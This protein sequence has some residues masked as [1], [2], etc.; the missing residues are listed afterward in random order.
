[1]FF[2][3]TQVNYYKLQNIRSASYKC[4]YC[5]NT[6]AS[7]WGYKI[8]QYGDGS[9][10]D[11]GR[12]HICSSCNGPSFFFADKQVS[13][14]PKIGESIGFLPDN[15]ASLYEEARNCSSAGAY[16]ASVLCCR[17]ILMNAAVGLGAAEGL[18]FIE[19][20]NYLSSKGYIPPNS[21]K[22]I[23]QIRTTGNIATHEIKLIPKQESDKILKFT[24]ML[25]RIVHELP[26]LAD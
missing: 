8:G 1:M 22:W 9:G 12:I 17:K 20:V 5:S 23:D 2:D 7:E 26:G 19:Y 4:G 18:K 24:E 15:V 21:T 10:T 6:V 25:L 16:T 14:L 13:P 11:V 3:R